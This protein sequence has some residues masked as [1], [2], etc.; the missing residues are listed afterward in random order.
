LEAIKCYELVLQVQ[1][2]NTEI[3]DRVKA[4]EKKQN[5]AEQND[6]KSL[7]ST[8]VQDEKNSF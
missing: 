7:Q 2:Y 6:A 8:P 4:L 1:P 5:E 3:Q